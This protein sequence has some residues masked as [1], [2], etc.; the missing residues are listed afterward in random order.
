MIRS[1]DKKTG[2]Y[3]DSLEAAGW[4]TLMSELGVNK[5]EIR[6]A[7][8]Q[9][10]VQGEG[11]LNPEFSVRPGFWFVADSKNTAPK[12]ADWVLDYESERGKEEA[13]RAYE[14]TTKKKAKAAIRAGEAGQLTIP[15]PPKPEL[16]AGED[17]FFYAQ[18]MERGSR[19]SPLDR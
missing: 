17:D 7:G 16:E 15:D 12:I 4:G 2:T 19:A 13:Q 3:A 8:T 5:V 1:V 10:L 18:G 14:K 9:F 11:D 6:D